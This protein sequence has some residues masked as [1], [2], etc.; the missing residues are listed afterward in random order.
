M[1][2]P[3]LSELIEEQQRRAGNITGA[4]PSVL[5]APK[6]TTT[7]EEFKKAGEALLK[8]SASGIIGMVG[9]WGNVY[10]QVR[11]NTK[12]SALSSRGIVNAI[13]DA[14][15]PDLMKLQGYKEVYDVGQAAAP[16]VAMSAAGL[17]G[18][19]G[20][21]AAG[22]AG[23]AA[24]AGGTG[25]VA[26]QVA[27][28][29]ALSQIAIG[30]LPSLIKGGLSQGKAFITRP[31]GELPP[32]AAE[33]NQVGPL[34]AGEMTG[35][36]RQLAKEAKVEQSPKILERGNVFRQEQ[37]Q[38]VESFL[39]N[40]INRA[41]TLA[42]DPVTAA[43][44]AIGAFNN[45]GKMLSSKLKRD[46]TRDFSDAKNSGGKVD[47]APVLS[48][49]NERLAA[50]PPEIGALDPLRNALNRIK[51]E[52][53]V[54][55]SPEVVTPSSILGADGKPSSMVTTP[56]IPDGNISI[57]IG[58]LQSNLSVWGDA[59]YSGKADFGKG[60]IFE[61]VAPG[62]VKG[63]AV[64]VL[65]GFKSSLD[66]A[67][68]SGVPGAE[69]LVKA[70]DSFK[71]NLSKIEEFSNRPLAK[72]FDVPTDSALTPELVMTR[73]NKA[74]PTERIFLTEVLSRDANGSSILD[75]MRRTQLEGVLTK[76]RDTNAGAPA[77]TP[78][79]NLTV[80]L[81]ELNKK[82][83]DFSFLLPNP[84]D[85]A[86]AGTAMQWLQK[87]TKTSSGASKGPLDVYSSSRIAGSSQ[88][89][90]LLA[91]ELVGILQTV[92][93]RPQMLSSVIFNK[94]TVTKLIAAKNQ[95]SLAKTRDVLQNVVEGSANVALRS[96]PRAASSEQPSVQEQAEPVPQD[97]ELSGLLEE[98]AR[99]SQQTPPEAPRRSI[100]EQGMGQYATQRNN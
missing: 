21:S 69:K 28:D 6:E 46:S 81:S 96:G 84:A 83:G 70:R 26:Q 100:V 58:R 27:P 20:R 7:L 29:S 89:G 75:T 54:V 17:P 49:I 79:M 56:A 38:G 80:L 87:A 82:D 43:T 2:E 71:V 60:N 95:G 52:Y 51:G 67:I 8:G 99:R 30:T 41:T 62:Q 86:A 66:E 63:I 11:G 91:R 19:F 78:D 23:E 77:G 24:V 68:S 53:T 97:E 34:T 1:A 93:N 50:I 39:G 37:A 18:L 94:D 4:S 55:G 5:E 88:Q 72:Y 64:S 65:N 57:D 92:I 35:D 59:V 13:S 22:L 9:G 15:G 25:L 12:A 48:V 36:R 98:A 44:N 40:I 33:L 76:A 45:Y 61:G 47:T 32:N 42:S 74:T 3:T 85:R 14:G 73:L 31:K 16:A 10:D 90:S